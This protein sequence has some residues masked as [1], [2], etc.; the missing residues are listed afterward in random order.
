MTVYHCKIIIGLDLGPVMAGHVIAEDAAA[1]KEWFEDRFLNYPTEG[2]PEATA[3]YIEAAKHDAAES[4]YVVKASRSTVMPQNAMN[5][6]QPREELTAEGV[7]YALP[8]IAKAD[9]GG[10]F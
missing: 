10:L 2:L 4:W 7:Q 5:F 1:A 6:Y 8:G 9:N 3:R